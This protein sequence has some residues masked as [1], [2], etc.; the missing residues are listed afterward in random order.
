MT[1]GETPDEA[2]N[3]LKELLVFGYG[4]PKKQAENP[5]PTVYKETS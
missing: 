2:Y 1:D 3:R 5:P 4:S